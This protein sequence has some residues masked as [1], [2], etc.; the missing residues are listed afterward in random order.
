[1]LLSND[2][3]TLLSVVLFIGRTMLYPALRYDLK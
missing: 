1:M 3:L 2:I